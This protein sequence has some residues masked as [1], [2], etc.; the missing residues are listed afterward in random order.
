[1]RKA[2]TNGALKKASSNQG[3]ALPRQNSRPVFQSSASSNSP[4][5]SRLSIMLNFFSACHQD[6]IDHFLSNPG[7]TALANNDP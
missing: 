6:Q 1:M 4:S 5:R 3:M 2:G 7:K